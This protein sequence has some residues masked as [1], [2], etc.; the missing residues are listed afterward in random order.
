MKKTFLMSF[1][2][3]LTLTNC[4]EEFELLGSEV[5]QLED[6][7]QIANNY[8]A[9]SCSD[10]FQFEEVIYYAS[11]PTIY[12]YQ[13]YVTEVPSGYSTVEL[14]YTTNSGNLN[15][16]WSDFTQYKCDNF[17]VWLGAENFNLGEGP[18]RF[19]LRV[20]NQDGSYRY[21]N[22]AYPKS[23]FKE[24]EI[25]FSLPRAQEAQLVKSP[26]RIAKSRY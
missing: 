21:C 18:A 10:D 9:C 8:K 13:L 16:V 2:A 24:G 5:V 26:I 7:T 12:L 6:K 4:Q 1:I 23:W 3:F 11:D 22:F 25:D 19:W 15:V 14:G 17:G 20:R